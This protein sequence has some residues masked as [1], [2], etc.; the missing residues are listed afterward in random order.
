MLSRLDGLF[1]SVARAIYLASTTGGWVYGAGRASL[2]RQSMLGP[3]MGSLT[4]TQ[5]RTRMASGAEQAVQS[6]EGT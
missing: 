3:A 5:S 6:I 1:G 2:R 4:G